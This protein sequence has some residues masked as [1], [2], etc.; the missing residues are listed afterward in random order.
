MTGVTLVIEAWLVVER[1]GEGGWGSQ[2][3]S[4]PSQARPRTGTPVF[5]PSD[6]RNLVVVVVVVIVVVVF[7]V[8]A[9]VVVAAVKMSNGVQLLRFARL[10][11]DS[12]WN[13]I[14]DL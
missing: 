4:Y 3:G 9:V 7:V 11:V 13:K 14:Y 10:N 2:R 1:G 6:G 5:G 8:V 12:S